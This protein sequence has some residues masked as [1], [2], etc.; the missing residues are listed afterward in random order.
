MFWRDEQALTES[1]KVFV[2][3]LGADGV[4][5]A[6]VDAV[7]VNGARPTTSWLPREIITDAYT[8]KLPE[9]LP[10]GSYRLVAGLYHAL[11]NTR[12]KLADGT[13]FVELTTLN[14]AP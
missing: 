14:F 13:D 8:L 4:P 3:L 12:L 7:P 6:Q 11:D 1:Y 10:A 5:R 2:Q 9:N